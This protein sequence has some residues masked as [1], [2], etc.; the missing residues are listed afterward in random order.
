MGDE[1]TVSDIEHKIQ[2]KMEQYERE[3][4]LIR[5]DELSKLQGWIL[6]DDEY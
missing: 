3:G 6:C 5:L 4:K 2:E 1:L